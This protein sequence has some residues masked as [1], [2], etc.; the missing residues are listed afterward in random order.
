MVFDDNNFPSI[1]IKKVIDNDRGVHMRPMPGMLGLVSSSSK[2]LFK[3]IM[4]INAACLPSMSALLR[5][6]IFI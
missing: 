5:A 2:V 1:L 4:F 6:F 3:L